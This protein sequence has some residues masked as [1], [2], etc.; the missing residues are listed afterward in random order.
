L[1][2]NEWLGF[3]I[4]MP[5]VFGISF[6]TPLVMLFLAKLGVMD[7]DAFRKK[8]RYIWFFMAVFAAII[9]P[10]VDAVSML[11]L[12]VPMSLLFELGIFMIKMSPR[13]ELVEDTSETDELIEV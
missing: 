1:R 4:F 3:A 12:W 10:S 6:Q 2:L 5:L 13:P 9:T 7:A 8:R 11:L